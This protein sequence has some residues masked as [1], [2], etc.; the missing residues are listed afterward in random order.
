MYGYRCGYVG[1]FFAFWFCPLCHRYDKQKIEFLLECSWFCFVRRLL[2]QRV[3]WR[4]EFIRIPDWKRK[5][6]LEWIARYPVRRALLFFDHF[7]QK[8]TVIIPA[9]G[10]KLWLRK[11]NREKSQKERIENEEQQSDQRSPGS[12]CN[13]Q[14]QDAG[15]FRPWC[16]GYLLNVDG[17]TQK[18]LI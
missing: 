6:F 11:K 8:A 17:N 14:V 18:Y 5:A 12:G 3:C 1:S 7:F 15:G 2:F 13:G 16:S 9:K 4:N 10:V